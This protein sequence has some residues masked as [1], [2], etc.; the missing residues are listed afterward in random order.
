[1]GSF[2]HKVVVFG[3]HYKAIIV[4]LPYHWSFRWCWYWFEIIMLPKFVNLH[5]V[6]K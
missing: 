6:Y 5:G 1:M 4:Q 2:V 3:A